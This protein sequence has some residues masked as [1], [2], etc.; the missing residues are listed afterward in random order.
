MRATSYQTDV[1]QKMN[2]QVE[3]AVEG[4]YEEELTT[5][6]LRHSLIGS[7]GGDSSEG[8]IEPGEPPP[9]NK[10]RASCGSASVFGGRW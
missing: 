2:L 3:A 9:A 7:W 8:R 1:I 4:R 5:R 6:K 10:V